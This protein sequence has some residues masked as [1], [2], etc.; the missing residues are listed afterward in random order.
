M[1]N[2]LKIL[3]L[4]FIITLIFIA[5]IFHYLPNSKFGLFLSND[6]LIDLLL[7]YWVAIWWGTVIE[8][9][10]SKHIPKEKKYSLVPVLILF[11]L[12]AMIYYLFIYPS[13]KSDNWLLKIDIRFID[14]LFVSIIL[15]TIILILLFALKKQII[16]FF[17]LSVINVI[18]LFYFVLELIKDKTISVAMKIVWTLLLL[19][20][21]IISIHFFYFMIYRKILIFKKNNI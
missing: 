10:F 11:N 21:S 19:G 1:R 8:C 16:S 13:R 12:L 3:Y 18:I 17:P 14:I 4:F 20:C 9:V 7:Y 2:V 6:L 5:I 15:L